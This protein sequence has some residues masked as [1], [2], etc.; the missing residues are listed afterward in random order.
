MSVV[1][2]VVWTVMRESNGPA[3]SLEVHLCRGTESALHAALVRLVENSKLVN[4]AHGIYLSP[5]L[6]DPFG[7]SLPSH[8]E[9][10][11]SFARE[12]G[13]PLTTHDAMVARRSRR[14]K[15]RSTHA[16]FEM[17]AAGSESG[18][19][20]AVH[21]PRDASR[22]PNQRSRRGGADAYPW[23]EGSG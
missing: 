20:G 11:Q 8:A 23:L 5:E 1:A 3:F 17:S 16:Q 13:Q 9:V 7:A 15:G 10:A 14:L 4:L 22:N 19:R 12:S 6:Y 18:P 21:S 2:Y